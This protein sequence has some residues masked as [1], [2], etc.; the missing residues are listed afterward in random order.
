MKYIH[1]LFTLLFLI[2]ALILDSYQQLFRINIP[3]LNGNVLY[4]TNLCITAVFVLVTLIYLGI[5]SRENNLATR[6]TAVILS[7]ITLLYPVLIYPLLPQFIT[8]HLK[9][10]AINI[11]LSLPK[12]HAYITIAC[13]FVLFEAIREFSA[14]RQRGKNQNNLTS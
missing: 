13:L 3:K 6:L 10:S 11:A 12:N 7:V 4:L 8:S 5:S 14:S 1:V 2:V 9:F